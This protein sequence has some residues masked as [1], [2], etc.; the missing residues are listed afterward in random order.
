MSGQQE[1]HP[2]I[3]SEKDSEPSAQAATTRFEREADSI[4]RVFATLSMPVRVQGCQA[5]SDRVRYHLSPQ[6]ADFDTQVG[7]VLD[8][9]AAALGSP[10]V[11]FARES[12]GPALDVESRISDSLPLLPL[13]DLLGEFQPLH[14]PLGMTTQGN[15]LVIDLSNPTSWHLLATGEADAGKSELMRTVAIAMALNSPPAAVRFLGID[16]TGRELALLEALPHR[17]ADL[18][19]E[20]AYA[21]E[22]L[23]WLA[24]EIA[25]RRLLAASPYQLF[26]FVDDLQWLCG[27]AIERIQERIHYLL[28]AGPSAGVHLIAAA[29]SV[30]GE[31]DLDAEEG[32]HLLHAQAGGH[33]QSHGP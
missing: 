18:A 4:E 21:T 32:Q 24:A 9:L 2:T 8:H 25:R 20:P 14:L 5:Q 15:P 13:L 1:R 31:V 12:S 11:R 28:A 10:S 33:R 7:D 6:S 17:M 3:I 26:L 30:N 22:L 19:L 27:S 16:A 29:R 23:D